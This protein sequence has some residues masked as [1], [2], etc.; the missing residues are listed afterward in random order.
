[1]MMNIG[2]YYIYITYRIM[3][4]SNKQHKRKVASDK[5]NSKY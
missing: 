1:M 5:N 3:M 4:K 2:I